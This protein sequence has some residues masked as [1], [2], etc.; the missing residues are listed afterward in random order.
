MFTLTC[1]A[2]EISIDIREQAEMM[3]Q[4]NIRFMELRSVDD[5]NVLDLSDEKLRDIKS[6]LSEHGIGV[7][8]IGSPLGK[9]FLEDDFDAHIEKLK[10]GLFVAHYLGVDKMR[11]FS[12]Y[13]KEG[14]I[15]DRGEEVIERLAKMTEIAAKANVK[16]MH[17]NEVNIYGEKSKNCIEMVEKINS[18]YF[19]LVFDPSNYASA[20]EKPTESLERVK[21]HVVY[22]HIKDIDVSTDTNVLAGTGDAMIQEVVQRLPQEKEL[23]LSLEP[24]LQH[25][26]QFRGFTGPEKFM[27]DHQALV[28]I[29]NKYNLEFD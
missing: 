4:C 12:F 20:K 23:F 17:E 24:H 21:R 18:P 2:D 11:V 15:F 8:C 13:S 27:Q 25:G 1:F 29:L 16:L 28:D 9:V 5:V 26:G 19:K 22:V 7:S 10:R 3:N 6:V 14:S